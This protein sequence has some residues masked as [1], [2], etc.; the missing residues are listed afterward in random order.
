MWQDN[1]VEFTGE[2]TQPR[3]MAEED[4]LGCECGGFTYLIRTDGT[5]VCNSCG[6]VAEELHMTRKPQK[7][8]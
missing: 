4:I 1:V 7:V 2:F 8:E 3:H 6:K 5:A